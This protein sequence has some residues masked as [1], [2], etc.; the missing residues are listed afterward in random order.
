[1]PSVARFVLCLWWK[2]STSGRT[3]LDLGLVRGVRKGLH[4]EV[5][6]VVL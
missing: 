1:M 4:L 3:G 6:C 5:C 2:D